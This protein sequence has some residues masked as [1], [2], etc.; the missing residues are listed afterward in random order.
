MFNKNH[1]PLT[2]LSSAKRARR[3]RGSTTSTRPLVA[4]IYL[5]ALVTKTSSHAKT[6]S[7]AKTDR[8]R[9]TLSSPQ[10]RHVGKTL[11]ISRRARERA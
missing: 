9:L 5:G 10:Q 11:G 1:C 6:K 2:P 3:G 7:H 4:R 8:L